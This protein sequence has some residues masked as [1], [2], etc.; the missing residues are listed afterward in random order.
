MDNGWH[1]KRLIEWYNLSIIVWPGYIH[2]KF[3]TYDIIDC[4]TS[5][6]LLV[7]YTIAFYNQ[8]AWTYTSRQKKGCKYIMHIYNYL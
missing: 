3:K 2:Y 8:S 1:F 5:Y 6:N 4:W 7:I